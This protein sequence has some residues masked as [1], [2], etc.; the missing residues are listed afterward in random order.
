MAR[1]TWIACAVIACGCCA[2]AASNCNRWFAK[3]ERLLLLADD[4]AFPPEQQEAAPV[5]AA[6]LSAHGENPREFYTR[7]KPEDGGR[8]LMFHLW[9][10]RV[11]ALRA[12]GQNVVGGGR[13]VFY[14]KDEKRVF[15]T[16]GSQ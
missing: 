4:Q 9:H 1:N 7:V 3:Q 14:N 5:V 12:A 10:E 11:V 16:V 2:I 13:T 15:K 8:V 6:A